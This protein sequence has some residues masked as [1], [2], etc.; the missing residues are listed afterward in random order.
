MTFKHK[1]S[2]RLALMRDVVLIGSLALMSC[3]IQSRL[4]INDPASKVIVSPSTIVVPANRSAD[5]YAVALD[6]AGDT[7]STEMMWTTTGGSVTETL[8]GGGLH[9]GRYQAPAAPG[10]YKVK[11][12]VNPGTVADSAT[13]TVS[14]VSVASLTL[15]PATADIFVGGAQQ[16]IATAMQ[17]GMT[18]DQ[19][20]AQVR[21]TIPAS[22]QGKLGMT[23]FLQQFAPPGAQ[24]QGAITWF[25]SHLGGGQPTPPPAAPATPT[26]GKPGAGKQVSLASAKQ[27]HPGVPENE[28]RRQLTEQGYTIIP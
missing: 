12:R 24:S 26:A 22:Q 4:A 15:S 1:L 27:K 14:S 18:Y 6:A 10:Q 25:R 11:A 28:L 19:A 8:M 3:K 16:F 23:P 13:V 21:A 7:A 5:L 17:Q 9:R 20:V 2:H